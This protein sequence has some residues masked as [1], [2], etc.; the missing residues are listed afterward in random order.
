MS[1]PPNPSIYHIVHFDRLESIMTDGGLHCDAAMANRTAAGTTI[2]MTN[3]KER[4]RTWNVPCYPGSFVG[5]YVPFYFCPRSVMLY[6]IHRKSGDPDSETD[7][8]YTGG[9]GEIVH[10]QADLQ[11]VVDW[12]NANGSRWAFST[13]NAAA[14]SSEFHIDLR[15]LD[16]VNWDAVHA[17]YWSEV[18]EAKQ[19]E[20]LVDGFFP[21]HL[22]YR[23]GVLSNDVRLRVGNLV[24]EAKHRPRVMVMPHWY[25]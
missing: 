8:E 22:V 14:A 10:L 23:I 15:Q 2:G 17:D 18:R 16:A 4:R 9:Q 12:A 1:P 21:W 3:I 20:F 7:L 19:A 25:Y 6:A 11:S 5:D 13:G 24:R